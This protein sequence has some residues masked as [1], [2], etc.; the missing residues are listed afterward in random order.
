MVI[1]GYKF[2]GKDYRSMYGNFQ[3][4]VGERY[5][6]D[7]PVRLCESGFHFSKR[8]SDA[9]SY[10]GK[11]AHHCCKVKGSGRMEEGQDKVVCSGIYIEKELNFV[12]VLEEL[13]KHDSVK[14]GVAENPNCPAEILKKLSKDENLNVKMSVI[15][16]LSC[17]IGILEKLSKDKHW[18]IRTLVAEHPRCSIKIL[19]ELSEDKDWYVRYA[20]AGHPSCPVKVSEKL[21]KDINSNMLIAVEESKYGTI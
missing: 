4:K 13:S 14:K 18:H 8:L 2:L 15:C 19:E 21:N 12:E 9:F 5:K 3:F 20:V 6:H 11:E 17:P 10:Y 1:E 7:G 16:N